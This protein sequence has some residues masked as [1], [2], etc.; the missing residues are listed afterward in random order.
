MPITLGDFFSAGQ[1]CRP[2]NPRPIVFTAV[3]KGR[4]LP[5]G[6]ANSTGRPVAAQVTAAFVFAGGDGIA[7]ARF[8]ARE[9]LRRRFRDPE[10]KIPLPYEQADFEL[11]L[12]YQ[13][14]VRVVYA[15]DPETKAVG[16]P[17]FEGGVDSIR[18]LIEVQ[19][20]NRMLRAYNEYVADEHPEVVDA[21]SFRGDEGRGPAV[22]ARASR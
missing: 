5:G 22:A 8:D 16:S 2:I 18:D 12:M 7:K 17:I 9:A 11:E 6:H 20:A 1:A 14:L 10:S 21:G 3:A 19:E 4:I 15:Y 13:L